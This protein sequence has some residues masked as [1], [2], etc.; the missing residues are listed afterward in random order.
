MDGTI[1]LNSP[2]CQ[3][4]FIIV[5]VAFFAKII[6]AIFN[7]FKSHV[8]GAFCLKTR[9]NSYGR[10]AVVTGCT[11]GI[12]YEYCNQL[13]EQ[14][15]NIILMA[16][17]EKVMREQATQIEQKYGVETCV[18]V[19]DFN[20]T[21]EQMIQETLNCLADKDV[22]ICVNNAGVMYEYPDEFY[23]VPTQLI[24]ATVNVNIVWPV[25]LCHYLVKEKMLKKNK[26]LIVFMSSMAGKDL[27][28]M[29]TLYGASKAFVSYIS[30]GLKTELL[31]TGVYTQVINPYYIATD[32]TKYNKHLNTPGLFNPSAKEYV[33]NAIRTFGMTSDTCGYFPHTLQHWCLSW[34]PSEWLSLLSLLWNKHLKRKRC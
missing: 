33:R 25:R 24:E 27:V 26:G 16:R 15:L 23:N 30:R 6:Y 10:W 21:H 5:L 17:N 32:M 7:E 34:I 1:F 8:L 31:G 29:L 14:G 28:P 19:A 2:L 3:Y 22:G 13:A 9:L 18:V 11:R 4:I 12:G 20:E